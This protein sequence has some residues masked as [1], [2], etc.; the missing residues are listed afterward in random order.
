MDRNDGAPGRRPLPEEAGP[1]TTAER[2][3]DEE[4]AAGPGPVAPAVSGGAAPRPERF[5][6]PEVEAAAAPAPAGPDWVARARE[7]ARAFAETA[8]RYDREGAFPHEHF[9]R[10]KA[11]GFFRLTVPRDFGGEEASLTLLLQVLEALA[12]GDG[13]T[14]LAL[15]WHLG[16]ILH[17]RA[18]RRW[19]EERFRELCRAVVEEAALINHFSTEPATGSPSRGGL[20]E[21]KAVPVPGGFRLYG[22]KTFGTLS[23]VARFF[24]VTATVADGGATASGGEREEGGAARVGEFLVERGE[25]L[26]IEKTWDTLGMRATASDDVVLEGAFVPAERLLGFRGERRPGRIDDGDGWYLFIPAVYLGIA[27]AA[28]DAAVHFAKTYRPNSLGGRPIADVPHVRQKIGEM[29]RLL[30]TARTVVYAV[31]ERWDRDAAG[32]AALRPEVGAAKS[33]ATNAAIDVVD[34][35]MRIVGGQSLSRALPLERLYRD[36]RAGLHNPPMDDA[37]LEML[38]AQALEEPPKEPRGFG[39]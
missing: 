10:L 31:A 33:V 39:V 37:V 4:T 35:A 26:R 34:R 21:T 18:S 19:P 17:Y 25:G 22:R 30:W 6:D 27:R 12:R 24:V 7:L 20:P 32:R 13:S 29:E 8:G 9:E 15:G 16:L 5:G 38:A 2:A 28:R 23:A 3:G 11:A 36:V 1:A 14:A